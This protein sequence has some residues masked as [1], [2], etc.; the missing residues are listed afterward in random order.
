MARPAPAGRR[1]KIVA[2][3]GP[4]SDSPQTLTAMAAAGMDVVR[5]PLAH[6]STQDAIERMARVREALPDIGILA[7]LPGPK[8]RTAPFPEGGA[9]LA[10][11]AEVRLVTAAGDSDSGSGSDESSD[12]SSAKA[13]A[14]CDP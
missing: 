6:G 9:W 14:V 5:I 4:A 10:P 12:A 11:G 1:T 8:I 7:D 3:I 2:T 13:I